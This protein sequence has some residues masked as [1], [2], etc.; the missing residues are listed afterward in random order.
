MT[1][2]A[3]GGM[4]EMLRNRN[5]ML[6]AKKAHHRWIMR[7]GSPEMVDVEHPVYSKMD[8]K[9]YRKVTSWKPSTRHRC[10]GDGTVTSA[11]WDQSRQQ[12]YFPGIAHHYQQAAE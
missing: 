9:G 2:E 12:W 11:R 5:L 6:M 1:G 7:K 3:E 4:A 8:P 10:N